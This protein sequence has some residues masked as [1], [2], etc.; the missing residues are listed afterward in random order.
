MTILIKSFYRPHLLDRCLR[1]IYERVSDAE[2][3]DIIVL[4]DGTPQ[5]Y[6]DKIQEKYPKV[7]FKF[8][9]YRDEKIEKIQKHLDGIERY[10]DVRIPTDLWYDAISQSS[11]ILIMT[12]DDVW[13]ID[14][15][16][17]EHYANEMKKHNIHILKLG[18]IL[19]KDSDI[20][21]HKKLTNKI[22]FH[23]P[24]FIIKSKK[25]YH[26]LLNNSFNLRTLL[27]KYN[28]L[29][30][31]WI[32]QL[33]VMYDIPMGMYR[34]DYLQ[35]LWKDR[36]KRVVEYLQLKNAVDWSFKHKGKTK[37]TLLNQRAM[38]TSYRSSAS[39]NAFNIKEHFDL[40]RFNYLLNELWYKDQMDAYEN[41]PND[42]SVNYLY[43]ILTSNESKGFA[44]RWKKWTE[45]FIEMHSNS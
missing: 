27:E 4:D 11:E 24:N 41:Y 6:L 38:A 26:L 28:L 43:D 19:E 33:W 36:Y 31:R 12:E 39:F 21:P 40:I 20:I 2:N 16:D 7:S 10:H 8:S 35:F 22:S 9:K 32:M 3:L 34:K 1:S 14:D 42:F 5:K 25:F 15:F 17:M 13:F 37:Y 44:D 30:R 18:R 45:G 23:N 29:P